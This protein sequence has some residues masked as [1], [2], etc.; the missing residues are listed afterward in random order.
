VQESA[1]L[2]E[3]AEI[4]TTKK[5]KRVPVVRDG[6]VVGIVSRADLVK[7]VVRQ[8][9]PECEPSLQPGDSTL[10]PSE[11]LAALTRRAH[12]DA[13]LP[14]PA[15]SGELSANGFRSLAAHFHEAEIARRQ[16][17]NREVE[18]THHEETRKLLNAELTDEMWQRMLKEARLAAQRGEEEHLLIRFPGELCS[19]HGRAVNAPDPS[20]PATLRG[21]VAQVFMR[22]KKEL[23]SRGFALHA[24]IIDFPGGLPGDI[25]LYLSWGQ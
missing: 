4:L 21:L 5:I 8:K 3:V 18:E 10:V 19:D 16:E 11:R 24:R 2:V 14:P 25:G 13:P 22:W 6:C 23:R 20:W 7:A 15:A 17:G 1:D 9:N 12:A